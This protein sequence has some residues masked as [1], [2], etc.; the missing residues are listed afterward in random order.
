MAEPLRNIE[1]AAAWLNIPVNTLRDLVSAR[2]VPFTRPGG[3]RHV[4]FAQEHL[5]AIV[6][7]G[8]VP[9]VK[10]PTRLEVVD[11][12]PPAGPSTP[13]PPPGPKSNGVCAA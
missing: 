7:S 3:T 12:H 1:Q 9:I 10:A 5:A 11:T 4:R 8:E 2:A 13:P 6:T